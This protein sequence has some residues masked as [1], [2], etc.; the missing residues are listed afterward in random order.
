MPSS[1]R[2]AIGSCSASC[3]RQ[4]N[5]N[6]IIALAL[7]LFTSQ[8]T[9]QEPIPLTLAFIYRSQDRQP[10]IC[11]CSPNSTTYGGG[12]SARSRSV[13][14]GLSTMSQQCNCRHGAGVAAVAAPSREFIYVP[15]AYASLQRTPH[16]QGRHMP[17]TGGGGGGGVAGAAA[18]TGA[19]SSCQATRG[20]PQCRLKRSQSLCRPVH[21]VEQIT[22][23][24]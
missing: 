16:R 9:S 24:V 15:H 23:S 6:N 22:T 21:F 14:E 2:N 17:G 5:V 11:T 1:H 7:A 8:S 12:S 20:N 10:L 13:P 19:G 3:Q 18:G 4:H